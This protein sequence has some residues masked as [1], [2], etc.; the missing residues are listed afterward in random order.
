MIDDEEFLAGV[1]CLAVPVRDQRRRIVAGLAVSA[2]SARYP[3]ERAR[4]HLPDLLAA[5][6]ELTAEFGE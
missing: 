2:P 6:Q 4:T 3:L 1:C 5:A